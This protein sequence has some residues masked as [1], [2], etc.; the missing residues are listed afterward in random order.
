VPDGGV[1]D[2]DVAGRPLDKAADLGER[3]SVDIRQPLMNTFY[4]LRLQS[5][6][7]AWYYPVETVNNS[8]SGFE[9]VV[10]GACLAAVTPVAMGPQPRSFKFCLS[11]AG[12]V[13]SPSSAV[14]K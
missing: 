11:A 4:G 14:K 3:S 12:A 13:R 6:M 7:S 9:R 5:G 8:E 2:G 1:G 10:Q